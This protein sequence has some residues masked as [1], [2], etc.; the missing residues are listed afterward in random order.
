MINSV[1][2]ALVLVNMFGIAMATFL[3]VTF[4]FFT[5]TAT[6]TWVSANDRGGIETACT[7]HSLSRPIYSMRGVANFAKEAVLE[8]NNY[9]YLT[10][11]TQ[12]RR[13]TDTYFTEDAAALYNWQFSNSNLLAQ[14]RRDYYAVSA[15]AVRN[16][17]VSMARDNGRY[18]TWEVQVPVM[19]YY[20]TGVRTL[21]GPVTDRART[22]MR[23]FVVQVAEQPPTRRRQ[24][25]IAIYSIS[26]API[27]NIES[28]ETLRMN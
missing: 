14:V 26:D 10:W 1:N 28:L 15:Q 8:L 11:D 20:Q 5:P 16:P 19:I 6:Y 25:G 12:L 13:V 24:R 18:R 23:V 22:Q 2:R 17:I 7:P 3:V 27:N 21:E 4:F 9:D